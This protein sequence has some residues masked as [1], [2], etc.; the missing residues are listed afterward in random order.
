MPFDMM[1]INHR[2][3]F[4]NIEIWELRNQTPI[5]HPFHIHDVQFYVLDIN[6]ATPPPNL[7]GRKDVIL[8][9]GGNGVVRFITQFET[10]YNDTLPYMYH[11]HMLTH[12]DDNMMG[13]FVVTAPS[14]IGISEE[15]GNLHGWRLYPNPVVERFTLEVPQTDRLN[16]EIVDQTGRVV[17]QDT[18]TASEPQIAVG[19]LPRGVYLIRDLHGTAR[20]RFVK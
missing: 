3:P 12:E 6:G 10:F 8:V 7:R 9:P 18:W 13:Q 11:C 16:Y 15:Q 19:H 5:S 1:M 17:A 20:M 14:N 2:I 4:N